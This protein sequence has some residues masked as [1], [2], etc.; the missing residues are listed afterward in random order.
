MTARSWD[1]DPRLR[2]FWWVLPPIVFALVTL[3][4]LRLA[5]MVRPEASR[6]VTDTVTRRVPADPRATVRIENHAGE[7][8]VR[9]ARD[10]EVNVRVTREG[11][12]R[13]GETAISVLA[14]LEIDVTSAAGIVD[15]RVRPAAGV[16]AEGLRANLD[17]AIPPEASIQVRN[18]SGR[19]VIE[20]P[21][22]SVTATTGRGIVDIVLDVEDT[23]E[24]V[25]RSPSFITNF[26]LDRSDLPQVR[27]GYVVG[28]GTDPRLR[29]EL[30]S[31]LGEVVIRH[32]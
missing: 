26:E 20:F 21:G 31:L 9:M 1:E 22:S 28:R 6:T 13:G 24:A 32:D 25:V 19:I 14:G 30:T 29:L 11:Q 18:G 8:R 17:V 2:R 4:M 23:F 16:P 3:G 27:E 10:D 7:V 12:A 5:D 15:V